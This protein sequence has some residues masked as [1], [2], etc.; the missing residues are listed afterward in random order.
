MNKNS[1]TTLS[2]ELNNALT[3]LK[4]REFVRGG[5]LLSGLTAIYGCVLAVF[6]L[7]FVA[8]WFYSPYAGV[9]LSFHGGLLIVSLWCSR[10]NFFD[11]WPAQK[12]NK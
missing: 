11:N 10:I 2:D 6:L 4:N 9:L 12:N 8:P 1:E 5:A 7:I 3:H